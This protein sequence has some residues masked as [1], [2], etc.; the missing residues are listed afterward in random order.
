MRY[1]STVFVCCIFFSHI[2]AYAKGA[3]TQPATQSVRNNYQNSKY[4]FEINYPD[5][6]ELG[7]SYINEIGTKIWVFSSGNGKNRALASVNILY[8]GDLLPGQT[9]AG[10]EHDQRDP[11]KHK[12]WP[13]G[14]RPEYVEKETTVNGKKMKAWVDIY[15]GGSAYPAN[16]VVVPFEHNRKIFELSTSIPKDKTTIPE[17]FNQI[18]ATFKFTD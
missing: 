15:A 17:F 14:F 3:Q 9:L 18:L 2:A 10:F 16:T 7:F 6:L 5:N 8:A 4:H 1:L 13:K 12:D 11:K